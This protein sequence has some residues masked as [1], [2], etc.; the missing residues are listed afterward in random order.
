MTETAWTTLRQ[1]LVDRYDD[2]RRKLARRL[3]SEELAREAL[4]EAWLHL[5]REGGGFTISRPAGYLLRTVINVAADQR[6]GASRLARRGEIAMALDLPDESP[7][8]AEC[9]E[10]RQEIAAL[11]QALQ[12]LTPRRRQILLASRIEG[13][14]M[15]QIAERLGVSQRLVEMELKHALDHCANRL[16][17]K[18]TRRFGPGARKTS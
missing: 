4:H 14:P 7:D 10:A 15:R 5:H 2:L 11:E 18:V 1:L 17:R 16:D 8:P 9:V 13:T 12:E 3:G 6:R